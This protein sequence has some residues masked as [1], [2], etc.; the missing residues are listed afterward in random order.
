MNGRRT[1]DD[2]RR[3][4]DDGRR[5]TDDGRR[6]TDDGRRTTDDGRRTTDDG[7][8]DDGRRTTDDGRRTT[9]DGRRTTDDGRRTT[10]DGRR[11]TLLE[12]RRLKKRDL[13]DV[14]GITKKTKQ[15]LIAQRCYTVTVKRNVTVGL[16]VIYK[17]NYKNVL[18]IF[19]LSLLIKYRTAK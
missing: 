18:L 5:T 9:D 10:D 19:S 7:R 11:T 14:P 8:R 6:T 13:I 15:L 1:T 2:G 3:T 16:L 17:W 4:T 12:S